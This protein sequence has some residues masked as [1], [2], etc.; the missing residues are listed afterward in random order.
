MVVDFLLVNVETGVRGRTRKAILDAAMSVLSATPAASLSDIA[1]AAEV[2]RSTL[3]R[4]FPERADL[5]R[6]LAIHVHAIS[7]AAI[8]EADPLSGPPV[9]AL[10]RVVESQL[11][12][13]PIVAYIY[14]DPAVLGDPELLAHLETG[15]EA[16]IEV[17]NRACADRA[18]TPP[19]WVRRAFWALLQAGFESAQQDGTPR[20]QIVDAIMTTLT[21]G[22]INPG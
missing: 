10:R 16:V 5:I 20:H 6:A 2:G 11:E 19:G 18:N 9:A 8:A 1:D 22:A 4:Y 12:L 3:H 21:E 15:D 13:G 7:N 14:V 17:L